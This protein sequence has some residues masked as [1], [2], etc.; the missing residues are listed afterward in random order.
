MLLDENLKDSIILYILVSKFVFI[1]INEDMFAFC[2]EDT[3]I[4]SIY[5]WKILLN[6]SLL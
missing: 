4:T 3:L 5:L 6:L 1:A 2:E